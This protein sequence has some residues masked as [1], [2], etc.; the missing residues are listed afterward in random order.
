MVHAAFA[1]G[2]EARVP[3]ILGA[4]NCERCGVAAI[5]DNPEA[6]LALAGGLRDRLVA[7]YGEGPKSAAVNLASDVDHVEPVRHLARLH[8]RNGQSTWA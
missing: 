7:V 6:V 2:R 3:T 8:A 5:E 4:N 1:G